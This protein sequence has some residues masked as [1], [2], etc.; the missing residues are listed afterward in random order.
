[1]TEGGN[2]DAFSVDV[3]QASAEQFARLKEMAETVT[4]VGSGESVIEDAVLESGPKALNGSLSV[5][6]T[7]AEI[8]QKA[9]IY[10]AE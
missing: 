7:V 6:D 5:E 8:V 1:M 4:A 10:L 2:G 3:Q 9:A